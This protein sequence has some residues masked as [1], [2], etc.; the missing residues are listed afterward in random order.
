MDIMATLYNKDWYTYPVEAHCGRVELWIRVRHKRIN[1]RSNNYVQFAFNA[2][3][4]LE[5][6]ETVENS[7]I[8]KF[9]YS[10]HRFIF[11]STSLHN[12]SYLDDSDSCLPVPHLDLIPI[13]RRLTALGQIAPLHIYFIH[14][15]RELYLQ[16]V[17]VPK[18]ILF[19]W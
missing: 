4:T 6:T 18:L 5:T 17:T 19:Q 9:Y 14:Q 7:S 12:S 16:T 2:A 8:S 13:S 11:F 3:E 15:I 10:W 1:F